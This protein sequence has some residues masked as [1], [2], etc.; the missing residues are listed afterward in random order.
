M[1]LVPAVMALLGAKAWWMPRWLERVLPRFDIEGEAVEREIALADW[2]EPRTRAA[3][4]ADGLA[5][6]D[7]DGVTLYDDV[8]L[9]VDAGGSLLLAGPDPRATRALA[10]TIAGRVAPTSGRLKVDGHLLPERAVW[11]RAHAGV[12][13]LGSAADPAAE[14]RRALRRRTRLLVVDGLDAVTA[15]GARDQV[16]AALRDAASVTPDLV[17]VATTT[18]PARARRVLGEAGRTAVAVVDVATPRRATVPLSPSSSE[19][20]A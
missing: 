7:H 10:L 12:A 11:V 8:A 3:A 20:I 16:A 9:R 4:V 2:P 19:V 17:V 6:S 15:P 14:V 5:L 18:D 13:L 1:T